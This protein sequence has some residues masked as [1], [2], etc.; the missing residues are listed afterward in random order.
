[1]TT[2]P[3][4]DARPHTAA[5]AAPVTVGRTER[6]FGFER[7]DRRLAAL[8]AV[9]AVLLH[10]IRALLHEP[11]WLDEMWV[12]SLSRAPL[13]Q[14]L[15]LSSSTPIGWVLLV[16]LVPGGV[17][18]PLRLVPLAFGVATIPL[19]YA[20]GR[21]LPAPTVA[22]ARVTG[23]VTGVM[24]MLAPAVLV[25]NDLK[26]YTADGFFALA[27]L[28]GAQLVV[29]APTARR[30]GGLAVL[31][32][33]AVPFS[34]TSA[35]VSVA[36][37]A[38]LATAALVRRRRDAST[39]PAPILAAAGAVVAALA[40]YFAL[41]IVP[42][43]NP[44][45]RHF[46][47][48][49]YLPAAPGALLGAIW[50]QVAF[51][52]P[53]AAMPAALL[54]GLVVAGCAQMVRCGRAPVA[55]AITLL[56]CEMIAAGVARR[57]P[58]CDIRTSHFLL[59]ASIATAA[60]GAVAVVTELHRRARSFAVVAA[61]GLVALVGANAYRSAYQ[62]LVPE[63]R[64][65]D[66]VEYVA[67]HRAASDVVITALASN[68]GL[69]AYWPGATTE[70][71]LARDVSMGFTTRARGVDGVVYA[72]QS[73]ERD[74]AV[75]LRDA[76]DLARRNR[77]ARLWVVRSHLLGDERAAWTKAFARFGLRPRAVPIGNEALWV[78]ELPR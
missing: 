76:L 67:R 28:V 45:L 60:V 24:V 77:S 26:Q 72:R 47:D 44:A 35:F 58:F 57:Y 30:A 23:V 37:F 78:V 38:S 11:Y 29:A 43:S 31:S 7:V 34:S 50:K 61:V 46:W 71:V 3:L 74:V 62:W 63:E 40:T 5:V 20:F 8:G 9:L 19:A 51:V 55:G 39:R 10:P 27:V 25:R 17:D 6:N 21:L 49:A 18:A 12:A 70:Y 2:A 53:L 64:V 13:A 75:A 69:S 15:R 65:Q 1:M 48:E 54:I 36:V 68:Y 33:L 42:Q 56:W 52:A 41:V 66:Q 32:V 14:Q 16:K 22:V 73:S 4:L 59:V